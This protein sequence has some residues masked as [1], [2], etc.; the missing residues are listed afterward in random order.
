[1]EVSETQLECKFTFWSRLGVENNKMKLMNEKEYN[2]E[3]NPISDFSSVEEFWEIFKFLVRPDVAKIGIEVSVFKKGIKPM[4]EDPANRLGG[5]L[6]FKVKKEESSTIWN[7]LVFRFITNDYPHFDL[8]DVAGVL[9]AVKRDYIV[10][11]IWVQNFQASFTNILI[12]SI[13][14]LFNIPETVELEL[15]SFNSKS[16]TPMSSNSNRGYQQNYQKKHN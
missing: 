3:L 15:K 7:E 6:S 1:M 14:S 11:Q 12:S 5:K 10:L 16:T 8:Q 2:N 9:Y 13:T 4:W